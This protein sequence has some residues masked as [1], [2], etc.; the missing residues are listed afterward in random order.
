[1]I[2]LGAEPFT[3]CDNEEEEIQPVTRAML[4]TADA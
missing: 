1:V 3:Q 2:E 4:Q